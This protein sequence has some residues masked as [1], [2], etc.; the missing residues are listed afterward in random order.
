MKTPAKQG[1]VLVPGL[2]C[3]ELLWQPQVVALAGSAECWI[4]DH[5]RSDTMADVAADVLREAPF[6]TFALAGLSMGG[7]VAL[8]IMRQASE[9][10]ARLALLD[11]SSRADTPEQ[12]KRRGEFIAL[13]ERG[14][15][16][17]V[18]DALLPNFVHPSRLSDSKLVN[19]I[20]KMAKNTG[21]YAFIRQEHAIISRADSRALLPGISCP[22]LVL[23]G[24]QDALTPLELH[25]EMAEALPGA[26]LEVVKD[27]GHLSTLERPVEVSRALERW[28]AA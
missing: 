15:F 17:G 22:A 4:A 8:E 24:R 13:A 10:V 7:Y 11:T 18:A 21:K 16:V 12:A 26:V 27:C 9:R 14:R 19:T 5:S 25:R 28:L 2:L 3:D 1:L 20:K 6:D 23:C